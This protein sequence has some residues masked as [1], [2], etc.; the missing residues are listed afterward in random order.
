MNDSIFLQYKEIRIYFFGNESQ[1]QKVYFEFLIPYLK[2]YFSNY[3][4]ERDWY[5]GPNYRIII[6]YLI[7]YE[8]KLRYLTEGFLEYCDKNF[9]DLNEEEINLNIEKYKENKDILSQIER[10]ESAEIRLSNHMRII[11]SFI[12]ENY[13]KSRFNNEYHFKLHVESLIEI[14]KYINENISIFRNKTKDAQIRYLADQLY[15]ILKLSIYNEKYS[16]LVYISHIEGVFS[17]A[18]S[19]N[20]KMKY[21]KLFSKFA[22]SIQFTPDIDKFDDE[23]H[24]IFQKITFELRNNIENIK[25][26]EKDYFSIDNQLELLQNNIDDINS[27]FHKELKDRDLRELA[28]HTEHLIFKVLISL[29]Y[30]YIHMIGINFNEKNIAIYLVCDYI[31]KKHGTNWKEILNERVISPEAKN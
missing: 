17:I 19:Y 6:K 15:N 25:R 16:V 9:R 21:K 5:G 20:L 26:Y 10:R 27:E 8:K 29:V 31:L 2:R 4:V 22:E 28:H 7:G 24:M 30:K 3:Y 1:K 13:V 23:F 14:Q 18:D 12:D 11:S